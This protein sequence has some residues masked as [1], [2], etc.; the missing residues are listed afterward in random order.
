LI[1]K[2]KLIFFIFFLYGPIAYPTPI[3]DFKN[4]EN[5]SSFKI[6]KVN[7]YIEYFSE[8]SKGRDFFQAAYPRLGFY[9]DIIYE[10]FDKNNIPREIIFVSMLESGFNPKIESSAGAIGLWQFMPSTAK[11]FGLRIDEWVDERM[12]IYHS[13]TAA[14]SYFKSLLKKFGS[15]E[16]ALAGYNC[17]DLN[18]KK[19]IDEYNSNDFW[20]LSKYTFPK[21]TKEYVPQII[22]LMHISEDLKKYNF[23]YLELEQNLKIKKFRVP[24]NIKLSKI[25]Y[26]IGENEDYLNRLNHSLQKKITPPDE[27]YEINI[28]INKIEMLYSKLDIIFEDRIIKK[29]KIIKGDTLSKIAIKLNNSVE[30]LYDLNNLNSTKIIAGKYLMFYENNESLIKIGRYWLHVVKKGDSLYKLSRLYE[31]PVDSIKKWNNISGS[32]ILI[33]QK[34][35]LILKNE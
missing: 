5:Q 27:S 4:L 8:N 22:A 14:V 20:Y 32:K 13:T 28:P 21:Q 29:Y 24:K 15:W 12:D 31:V 26:L 10:I 35:K 33:G 6:Q 16:L 18:V 25:A 9:K 2:L 23:G 34:I 30:E 1:Y 7:K 3:E 17:G 11:I 19:A